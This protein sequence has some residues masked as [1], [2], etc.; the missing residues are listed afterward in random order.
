MEGDASW[1]ILNHIGNAFPSK[2]LL[3]TIPPYVK[4][5][6]HIAPEVKGTQMCQR[7]FQYWLRPHNTERDKAPKNLS[8]FSKDNL[9]S[10]VRRVLLSKIIQKSLH[11]GLITKDMFGIMKRLK[12]GSAPT[13]SG[14]VLSVMS[15]NQERGQ[16]FHIL[17]V[18]NSASLEMS[19]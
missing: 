5:L 18:P 17:E 19:G 15:S 4:C 12:S 11:I 13:F 3:F 16:W 1:L 9:Y 10:Q 6:N 14:I 8:Y 7:A 2:L